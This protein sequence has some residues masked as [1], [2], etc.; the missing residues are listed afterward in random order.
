MRTLYFII[1]FFLT[2]NVSAQR[3]AY[4]NSE[5]I[6]NKM[7]EYQSAQDQINKLTISWQNEVEEKYKEI[8]VLFKKY[9]ADKI[10]LTPEM[11]SIR[12]NE[13]LNKE[14]EAKELQRK[15]FGPQGELF[16]KTEELISPIQDKIFNAIEDFAKEKRYDVIFDQS[17][18]L[19]MLFSDKKLDKSDNIIKMLGL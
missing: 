1:L 14:N 9:Q 11:R 7:P 4:V 16:I 17:S 15:R 8:D 6:L 2:L 5:Y 13:I 12:E 3:F 10:L 19:S 18:N